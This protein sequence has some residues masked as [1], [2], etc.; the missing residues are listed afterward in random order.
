MEFNLPLENKKVKDASIEEALLKLITGDERELF[1]IVSDLSLDG[2]YGETLAE[3]TDK[4][5]I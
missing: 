4:R 1:R 5:I 3:F 2:K